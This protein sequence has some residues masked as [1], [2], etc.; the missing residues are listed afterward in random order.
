MDVVITEWALQSYLNLKYRN[1]FTSNEYWNV[2]RPDV[3]LLRDAFPGDP[4]FKS[5]RF[6]GPATDKSG[7]PIADG[8]KMKWH[9]IGPG[10]VQLRVSVAVLQG[11]A[12]LCDAYVKDSDAK[13][14]RECAKLKRRINQ[15]VAG[16][17]RYRGT[18]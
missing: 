11:Q 6:W 13:D 4:K 17:Y 10:K 16:Q 1:V 12:F 9:N 8:Y 5:H 14:K 18:I 2:I 7:N 15:I 3:E